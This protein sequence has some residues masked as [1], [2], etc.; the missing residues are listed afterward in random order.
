ME[1]VASSIDESAAGDESRA[2]CHDAVS[3]LGELRWLYGVL[4]APDVVD[5]LAQRIKGAAD[6]S[7]KQRWQVLQIVG[8]LERIAGKCHQ[9]IT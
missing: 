8:R 9:G 3:L 2:L 6:D 1:V 5:E 7:K 4:D